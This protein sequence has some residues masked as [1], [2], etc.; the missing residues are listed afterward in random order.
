MTII[1][2]CDYHH[3]ASVPTGVLLSPNIHA[4]EDRKIICTPDN[5]NK[6]RVKSAGASGGIYGLAFVGALI[7]YLQHAATFWAGVT[8]FIKALVWPAM[9]VYYIMDY[10]KM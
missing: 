6:E 8:G 10:L 7:Y 3:N 1:N 2:I 9:L 5:K 4:M